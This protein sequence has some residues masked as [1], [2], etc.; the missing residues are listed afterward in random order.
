MLQES[1]VDN[2]SASLVRMGTTAD[3]VANFLRGQKIQGKKFDTFLCPVACWLRRIT[4]GKPGYE[5]W[6]CVSSS[7]FTVTYQ[8]KTECFTAAHGS[9]PVGV[10]EFIR[11]FDYQ[12]SYSDLEAPLKPIKHDNGC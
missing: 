8:T 11:L 6:L 10:T 12:R 7:T 3:N 5:T 9:L 2:L 4:P 1:L